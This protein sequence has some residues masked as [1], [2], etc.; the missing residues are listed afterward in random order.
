MSPHSNLRPAIFG[1][2]GT[3][4][5]DAEKKFFQETNPVGAILFARNIE[6]LDQVT[7]LTASLR[8]VTGN[9]DLLV[10]IDQE[11]GRVARLKPPLWPEYP[12]ARTFGD[13]YAKNPD[14]ALEKV[15]DNYVRIGQGLLDLGINVDCAPVLDIPISG[16]HDVIGDRAFAEKSWPVTQLGQSACLGLI[17]SGVLP[18]I[19]HIPGHGRAMADSHHE[20]PRVDTDYATLKT[21]DFAP[22]KFLCDM[23]LAMTA[24]ILYT[25][26]D[27]ELPATLSPKI[28]EQ[29][30]RG[31]IGYLGVL[32]SDD[33][34]MKAL[35]GDFAD[36]TRQ[37]LAA[38]CDLVLHCS[39]KMDEMLA[40]ASA[41]P[42]AMNEQSAQRFEQAL[43]LVL[44]SKLVA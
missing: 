1:I 23:P 6:S 34:G 22:F 18:V 4:L 13:L 43:H 17:D 31:D 2:S 27:P 19:K 38:G 7:A 44:H 35:K 39:G 9:K 3:V 8:E 21:T 40:A 16:A 29:V 26:I 42:K 37:T 32:M 20:L 30:I 15:Y 24:H 36:L 10:L 12:P 28:V 5:T 41:L 11:G 14:D 33:I 25:D